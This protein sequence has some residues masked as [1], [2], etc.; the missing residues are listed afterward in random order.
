MEGATNLKGEYVANSANP[1]SLVLGPG[2]G[3]DLGEES[4]SDEKQ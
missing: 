1:T 3:E 2:S 4:D